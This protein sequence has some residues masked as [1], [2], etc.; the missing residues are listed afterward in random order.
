MS[1]FGQTFGSNDKEMAVDWEA[2]S[3][4][5]LA[6]KQTLEK[7]HELVASNLGVRDKPTSIIQSQFQASLFSFYQT[8]QT[9]FSKWLE[10][11]YPK[12]ALTEQKQIA[13]PE[14][15]LNE[16]ELIVVK[17][18]EDLPYNTNFTMKSGNTLFRVL[19]FWCFTVGPFRTYID[20]RNPHESFKYG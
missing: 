7:Q 13:K 3:I 10:D 16:K 18:Y 4:P 12:I 2:K 11:E 6:Y 14:F 15:M 1:M 20:K 19:L 8:I 5:L 17:N 9:E